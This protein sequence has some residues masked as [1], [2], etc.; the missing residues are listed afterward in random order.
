MSSPLK[1]KIKSIKHSVIAKK[2]ISFNRNYKTN[3]ETYY[4]RNPEEQFKTSK[5]GLA[6]SRY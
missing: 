5:G 6:N 1:I 4:N 3:E 2:D